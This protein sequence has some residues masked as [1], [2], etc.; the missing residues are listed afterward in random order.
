M[1]C[2]RD[3]TTEREWD[4]LASGSVVSNR[5][6]SFNCAPMTTTVGEMV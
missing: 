6:D 3:P 5:L 1:G 4:A 2:R